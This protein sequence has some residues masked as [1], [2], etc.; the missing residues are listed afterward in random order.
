VRFRHAHSLPICTPSRN[1]IM[2]G[3]SNIRNYEMFG[4]LHH[5]ETTFGDVMKAAGYTTALAGKW[6]LE[7][8]EGDPAMCE[9][10]VEGEVANRTRSKDNQGPFTPAD[11][12][13]DTYSLASP[14]RRYWKYV[15]WRTSH[16]LHACCGLRVLPAASG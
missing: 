8:S 14:N 16:P 2:T 4:A 13:F 5:G 6:Q 10:T 15:H 7:G 3:R 1:K 9:A 12:G 11:F